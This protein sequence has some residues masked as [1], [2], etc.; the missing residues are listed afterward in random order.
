MKIKKKKNAKELSLIFRFLE[1]ETFS[2]C[3]FFLL[4]YSFLRVG[5]P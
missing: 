2:I 4:F 1:L 5:N 3:A